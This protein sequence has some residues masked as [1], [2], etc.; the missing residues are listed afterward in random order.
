MFCAVLAAA[1]PPIPAV[2]SRGSTVADTTYPTGHDHRRAGKA[3][4]S[5]KG[6]D[7]AT[8]KRVIS[9]RCGTGLVSPLRGLP[10]DGPGGVAGVHRFPPFGENDAFGVE[11]VSGQDLFETAL[12]LARRAHS[13]K[14]RRPEPISF[15]GSTE[16]T[17]CTI[18]VVMCTVS[19]TGRAPCLRAPRIL[20][21]WDRR[22]GVRRRRAAGGEEWVKSLAPGDDIPVMDRAEQL[23]S[24][25]TLDQVPGMLRRR[26]ALTAGVLAVCLV[27]LAALTVL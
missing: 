16:K 26:I 7:E 5:A 3:G 6:R 25:E 19:A 15:A 24:T 17:P 10:A 18:T 11:G 1:P 22:R 12:L 14:A 23:A 20:R 21:C 27:V 9:T 13:L 4:R 8:S 2:R